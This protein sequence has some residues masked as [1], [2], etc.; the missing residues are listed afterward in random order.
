MPEV[1]KTFRPGHGFCSILGLVLGL[2]AY[3]IM[4]F[5]PNW[6]L[7]VFAHLGSAV[8]FLLFG[9]MLINTGFMENRKCEKW[10]A[11]VAGCK[12][13]AKPYH[14]SGIVLFFIG[15]VFL[16]LHIV[17]TKKLQRARYLH[18]VF[19]RDGRRYILALKDKAAQDKAAAA[20]A[21]AETT[22]VAQ[23]VQA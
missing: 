18:W 15:I 17:Q 11:N 2:P 16:I 10:M 1:P 8:Y 5:Y 9:I 22:E 3:V 14:I 7:L 12:G 6:N 23:V 13:N 21:A 19:R 20:A 4:Y